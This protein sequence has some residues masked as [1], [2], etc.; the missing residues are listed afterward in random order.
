MTSFSYTDGPGRIKTRKTTGPGGQVYEDATYDYDQMQLMLS[1][2][3]TAPN[4]RGLSSYAY[5]PLYQLRAASHTTGVNDVTNQY[6]YFNHLNISRFDEAGS[7]FHYDDPAHPDRI[8]AISTGGGAPSGKLFYDDNGNTLNLGS[9]TFSYNEK[10]EL[11]RVSTAK[12]LTAEYGYDHEGYRVSKLVKEAQGLTRQTFFIRLDVEIRDG[13]PAYFVR[14]NNLRVAIIHDGKT[15]F[16]HSDSDGSTAY[17][18]SATGTKLAAIAYRPFGNLP[19]ASGNPDFRTFSIHPF[20]AESGLYYMRR[21]YYAPETGRFLTPDPLAL[22]Q[23]QKFLSNPKALHPYIYVGNDPLNNI[24]YD[25]LSFWS[26]VGAIVGVAA[27]FGAAA[28][29]ALPGG[30]VLVV[31]G[32]IFVTCI[33][34]AIA[35]ANKGNNTGEFFRGFMIGL[36]AGLNMIIATAVFGPEVGI[37]L[38]VINFLAAFDTVAGNKIYQGILGWSSWLMPMSWAVNGLGLV[39]FLINIGMA[40]ITANQADD[41]KIHKL[42][43]NFGTGAIVMRG[44]YIKS[45]IAF[46]MGNFVFLR[47]KE[48]TAEAHE[49]GHTL[50]HAAFG[51]AFHLI[52]AIDEGSSGQTGLAERLADSHNPDVAGTEPWDMWNPEHS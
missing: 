3:D 9:K 6:E 51:S 48:S 7:V 50:S 49:T 43:I 13:S 24:D 16:V 44:G 39:V 30:I 36:N 35:S 46:D 10:N 28:L 38:G 34:Y 23:P 29:A 19:N 42:S 41:T 18:T 17:F 47:S 31:L 14:L 45:E 37:A 20:D 5:D 4:G 40:L 52:G 12:G 33:S 8:S 2:D 32:V 11:S 1:G 21:R 25:G 22:N 27:A 26:V 15:E